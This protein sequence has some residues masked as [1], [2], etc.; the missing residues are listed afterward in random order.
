MNK[1][2]VFGILLAC[3]SAVTSPTAAMAQPQSGDGDS[4]VGL[5]AECPD[6]NNLR[7]WQL[8][9]AGRIQGAVASGG[10]A[11]EWLG[12]ADQT[13]PGQALTYT[14]E[15]KIAG[16]YVI[17]LRKLVP[18]GSG[19]LHVDFSAGW[20]MTTEKLNR[21]VWELAVNHTDGE[22]VRAYFAVRTHALKISGGSA[23]R[24]VLDKIQLQLVGTPPPS[25]T[26]E[27][28][29]NCKAKFVWEAECYDNQ[30][31]AGDGVKVGTF[32][33]EHDT[34]AS[35]NYL[36][37]ASDGNE[38][39]DLLP[40]TTAPSL[41]DT[42]ALLYRATIEI[43]GTYTVMLRFRA[44]NGG[45]QIGPENDSLWIVVYGQNGSIL[46]SALYNNTYTHG[47]WMWDQAYNTRESPRK[48]LEFIAQAGD[49]I[50]VAVWKRE[51]G[52][53]LDKI[54]MQK[55]S[56]TESSAELENIP[57]FGPVADNVC[58]ITR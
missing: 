58:Q 35:N 41:D 40:T 42:S 22:P 36:V 10:A 24:G 45:T 56:G 14:F 47:I 39:M 3:V 28:A 7:D 16:Y 33:I 1:R 53:Q 2:F 13:S 57:G 34:S 48:P 51:D 43:T 38:N 15:I 32:E 44:P 21:F 46:V 20:K 26:G 18:G 29:Q 49:E 50:T 4:S 30:D 5:E 55:I 12:G 17:Y 11:I 23:G 31:Q 25:G 6:N 9:P 8:A 19:F 27:P 52:S 37:E 54:I